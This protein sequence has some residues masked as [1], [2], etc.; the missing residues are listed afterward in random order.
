VL[1]FASLA[2]LNR[3][4]Y[5]AAKAFANEIASGHEQETVFGKVLATGAKVA[6]PR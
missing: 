4:D 2:S 3:G 6:S 5:V 1:S